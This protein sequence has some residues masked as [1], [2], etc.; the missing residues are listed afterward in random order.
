MFVSHRLQTLWQCKS[1]GYVWQILH[2]L[3]LELKRMIFYSLTCIYVT[4]LS[5]AQTM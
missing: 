3:N 4:M 5:I 1:W 2:R